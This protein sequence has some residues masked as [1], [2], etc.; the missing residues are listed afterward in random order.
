MNNIK[1]LISN[2]KINSKIKQLAKKLAKNK[3]LT[4]ITVAIGARTFSKQLRDELK[5]LNIKISN[6]EIKLRSYFNTKST[7]K[8]KIIKD[9]KANLKNKDVIIIEDIVDT[10]LTLHFLKSY[11]KKKK[12]VASIKLCSLLSKPSRRKKNININYLGFSIPNKFIVGYGLD[13]NGK[14]RKLN[15]IGVMNED[16]Q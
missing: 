10:G 15:Y 8:I 6:H 3:E 16:K 14:Y 1:V 11:L 5:K 4:F 7:G 12:K 2:S 13:Y 9:I